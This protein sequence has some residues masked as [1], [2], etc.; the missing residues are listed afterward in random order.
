MIG[1]N[2]TRL[3][4]NIRKLAKIEQWNFIGESTKP[5]HRNNRQQSFQCILSVNSSLFLCLIYPL[6][7]SLFNLRHAFEQNSCRIVLIAGF[8]GPITSKIIFIE[9]IKQAI[10][11]NSANSPY[12]GLVFLESRKKHEIE[13]AWTQSCSS[14]I[15]CSKSGKLCIARWTLSKACFLCNLHWCPMFILSIIPEWNARL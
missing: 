9:S 2:A 5:T 11:L 10:I 8:D 6:P 13:Q 3:I 15:G 4:A 7:L 14:L 1:N 12:I